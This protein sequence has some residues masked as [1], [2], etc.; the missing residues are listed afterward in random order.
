MDMSFNIIGTGVCLPEKIVT[1]EDLSKIVD[2]NDE[3]IT[4]RVGVRQRHI[5]TGETSEEALIR[6]LKEEANADVVCKRLI[7]TEECFWEWDG[8]KSH[9]VAFYYLIDFADNVSIPDFSD[10]IPQRDNENV[11]LGWLPIK[12]LDSVTIYPEFLKTEILE[13]DDSC[14]HFITKY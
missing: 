1:N 2:T 7:W 3:W 8:T 11:L 13:L 4:Q 10:F 14:K 5:S 6:E 9:T 12:E